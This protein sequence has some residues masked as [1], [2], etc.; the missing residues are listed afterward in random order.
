[1][2]AKKRHKILGFKREETPRH[3][4]RKDNE[5]SQ[6]FTLIEMLLVSA[7]IAI[8]VALLFPALGKTREMARRITCANNLK[9]IG[10]AIHYYAS[11]Y[12]DWTYAYAGS[13]WDYVGWNLY[14]NKSIPTREPKGVYICPSVGV[15]EGGATYYFSCYGGG[16]TFNNT[17]DYGALYYWDSTDFCPRKLSNILSGTIMIYPKHWKQKYLSGIATV[18]SYVTPTGFNSYGGDVPPLFNH[19]KSDNFLF[20]DGHIEI[21]KYGDIQ[22]GTEAGSYWIPK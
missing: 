18:T 14:L 15:P 21:Y 16:Y 2:F 4:K 20:N 1:M 17:R 6:K 13:G 3:L 19:N 9:Q 12:N 7:I 5:Y 22:V 11:D 10:M 8:L